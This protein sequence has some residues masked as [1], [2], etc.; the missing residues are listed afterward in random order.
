[1]KNIKTIIFFSLVS[2]MFYGT[3]SAIIIPPSNPPPIIVGPP[4]TSTDGTLVKITFD[5]AMNTPYD[6]TDFSVNNGDDDPVTDAELESND[7]IIDLT[8]ETPIQ[9]G[10]TVTVSYSGYYVTSTDGGTLVDFTDVSVTNNSTVSGGGGQTYT[11]KACNENQSHCGSMT[12]S[13][14]WDYLDSTCYNPATTECSSKITRASCESGTR[15]GCEWYG[16]ACIN[17]YALDHCT[18]ANDYLP[19][20]WAPCQGGAFGA[21]TCYVANVSGD[22]TCLSYSYNI[23]GAPTE[24]EIIVSSPSNGS[25]VTSDSANLT[26]SWWNVN[27]NAWGFIWFSF[28]KEGSGEH[29]D[30]YSLPVTSSNGS[31]TIPLSDFGITENGEWELKVQAENSAT[32]FMDLTPSPAYTLNFNIQGNSNPYN[33]TDWDTWYSEHAAGGYSEPSDFANAIVGFFEP[34]FESAGEFANNA[35]SYFSSANFYSKGKQLGLVLPTTQAYL[36]KINIFFGNFPLIQFFE[37]LTFIMLGI[38]IVR[39]IFKFIPFFG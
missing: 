4:V 5:K 25:A 22:Y 15:A 10:Q 37:L 38:F 7:S 12:N 18:W 32:L 1:M 16:G 27:P 29:S 6:P 39:T 30:N 17:P 13:C 26:G 20:N 3:T 8:V 14:T 9:S 33:F 23:S 36:N 35:M 31:F 2:L 28:V 21:P 24:T 34:I 19:E 11:L